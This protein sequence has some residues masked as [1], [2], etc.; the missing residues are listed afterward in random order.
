M[1]TRLQ[2]CQLHDIPKGQRVSRYGYMTVSKHTSDKNIVN[3]VVEIARAS[4]YNLGQPIYLMTYVERENPDGSVV[5]SFHICQHT[6][7]LSKERINSMLQAEKE[8][9]VYGSTITKGVCSK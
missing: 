1:K 3:T 6:K 5:W 7:Y 8:V 2:I 9:P 4:G